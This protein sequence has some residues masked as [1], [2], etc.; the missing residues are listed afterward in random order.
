MRFLIAAGLAALW[1]AGV[2]AAKPPFEDCTTPEFAD[3]AVRDGAFKCVE[4]HEHAFTIQDRQAYVRTLRDAID[5]RSDMYEPTVMQAAEAGLNLFST[6]RPFRYGRFTFIFTPVV[7]GMEQDGQFYAYAH[8]YGDTVTANAEC[9]V[10]INTARHDNTTDDVLNELSN[11]VVHEMFHCIQYWNWTAKMNQAFKADARWW[12]EGSAEVMGHAAF[13]SAASR[14]QRI[15]EFHKAIQTTPLTRITYPNFVFF[16]WLWQKNPKSVPAL[17]DA[18]PETG[19]EAAQRAALTKVI[20][21]YDLGV[22]ATE[23]ADGTIRTPDGAPISPAPYANARTISDG[24]QSG[25]E[26]TPLTVVIEDV[27][28]TGGQYLATAKGKAGMFYKPKTDAPEEWRSV[29]MVSAEGPCSKPKVFRFAGM[30][31]GEQGGDAESWTLEVTKLS[32]CTECVPDK[33]RDA[34]LLGQWR[35]INS[36]IADTV[37]KSS[38]GGLSEV[39][40]SGITAMRM[41]TDGTHY[42]GWNKVAIEGKP[43]DVEEEGLFR[44]YLAG[45]VE[46]QWSASEGHMKICYKSSEAAIQ[47]TVR[48]AITDPITFEEMMSMGGDS[49]Q[50][51]TYTCAGDKLTIG[52]KVGHDQFTIDFEKVGPP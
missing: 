30:A 35:A 24:G 22:F 49:M 34:C 13:E 50:Q 45:T 31:A 17:I 2:A 14:D 1:L 4:I 29:T 21:A 12:I 11:S 25:F 39:Q 26:L 44:I 16:S 7:K 28:F 52:G 33:E 20:S 51:W 43:T 9:I 48:G 23:Y 6:L 38:D 46:S 10:Q 36:S 3:K 8:P 27:T 15:K 37:M 41:K 40:V 18:M 5:E 32:S 19:G 42:I 47:I